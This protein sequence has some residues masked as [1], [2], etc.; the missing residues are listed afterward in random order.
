MR[1]LGPEPIPFGADRYRANWNTIRQPGPESG[2]GVQVKQLKTFEV[3]PFRSA[4]VQG[5][6]AH[7]KQPRPIGRP[8]GA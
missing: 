8:Y 5:Y 4:A 7:L 6:L 1:Q 3:F 2:P